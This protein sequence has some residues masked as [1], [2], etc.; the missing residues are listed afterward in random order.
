MPY[1]VFLQWPHLSPKTR[2]ESLR[3]ESVPEFVSVISQARKH[4][5]VPQQVGNIVIKTK[6]AFVVFR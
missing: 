6:S 2:Q 5:T 1:Q 3:R 4:V